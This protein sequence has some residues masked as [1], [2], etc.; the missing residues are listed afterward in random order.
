M[1]VDDFCTEGF[2]LEAA[3]QFLEAVGAKEINLFA[4]GKY[5]SRFV[6]QTPK[7]ETKIEPYAERTYADD[8]FVGNTVSCEIDENALPEFQASLERL[9]GRSIAD[10][11]LATEQEGGAAVSAG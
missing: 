7:R 10:K 2:S 4:F 11:L 3:R 9:R 8:A 5:G 1:V 6:A